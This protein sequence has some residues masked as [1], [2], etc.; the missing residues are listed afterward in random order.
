MRYKFYGKEYEELNE[1]SMNS[2]NTG[3]MLKLKLGMNVIF[4]R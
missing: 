2:T 4:A 3:L 1:A